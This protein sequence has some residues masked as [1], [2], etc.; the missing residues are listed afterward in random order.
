M[1]RNDEVATLLEEMADH[2]EARDVDYKHKSY[3][4]AADSIRAHAVAVE[5]LH[6]EGGE[7]ALAEIDDVGDA[8]AAKTAEYLEEDAIDEL[9]QLREEMPVEMD[10]L[11]AV[12]GVG[13]K[14][15]AALYEALGVETLDDLEAAAEAGEI[16]EVGG[17]GATT[18]TARNR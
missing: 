6:A 13:P 18:E 8:I 4:R 15:V 11:T 7:D 17:F 14:T 1:S 16:R 12:E 10:A 2:L 9:D 3:R 5:T